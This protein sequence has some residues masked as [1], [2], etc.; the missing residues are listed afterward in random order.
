MTVSDAAAVAGGN[1][2]FTV[3]LSQA[4]DYAISVPYY[5]INGTAT[6]E[7]DYTGTASTL[8]I[9]AGS[10]T[11]AIT[12]PTEVD[13]A[14][15]GAVT[16]SVMLSDPT[17]TGL[18]PAA[19][20]VRSEATG[21]IDPPWNPTVD[22]N[23]P[24]ETSNLF[25]VSYDGTRQELD[26]SAAVGQAC[27]GQDDWHVVLPNAPGWEFW[28]AQTGGERLTPDAD[29]NIIYDAMPASGNYSNTLWVCID[30][31]SPDCAEFNTI[32]LTAEACSTEP[33]GAAGT[34][35]TPMV[36]GAKAKTAT[37]YFGGDTTK[38]YFVVSYFGT[39]VHG[40]AQS[41]NVSQRIAAR[42]RRPS[43]PRTSGSRRGTPIIRPRY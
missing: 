10:T 5:T 4:V 19:N 37:K 33:T 2:T 3:T 42:S 26:L 9:A 11:G 12:I 38:A 31:N 34:N 40:Q 36:D 6:A 18:S 22:I 32:S 20:L 1:E 23:S 25:T 8:V 13:G 28:T 41:G 21:V 7:T 27:T 35:L 43:S 30:P 29:G 15:S 39:Q 24:A 14:A 16:F 17:T